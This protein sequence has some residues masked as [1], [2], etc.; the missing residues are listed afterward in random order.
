MLLMVL[1]A[2]SDYALQNLG[3]VINSDMIRNIAETTPREAADLI[4]LH[5]AFYI[6][7]VGIL[8]AVLVYRTHIEFASFGKEIRSRLLLFMLGFPSSVPLPP[9]HTK[10]MP[11]S[12]AITNRFAIISIHSIIFTRSDGIINVLL[13]PKGNLSFW[14]SLRK[15]FPL[16][17]ENRG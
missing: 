5:A 10:N 9:F 1:S 7:I 2:A 15:L 11:L 12:D 17:T 14:T 6:L 8:P 3:V 4:T 13:T 16:R